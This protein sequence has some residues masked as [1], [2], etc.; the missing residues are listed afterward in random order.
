MPNYL[1]VF[2]NGGISEIEKRYISKE[3]MLLND[4]TAE[5]GI[6]LSEKDCADIAECRYESLKENERI[7]VGLGAVQKIIESFCDSGYVSQNNFTEIVEGLLECFYMIKSE[8]FDKVSDEEVLDFLKY[9]FE[10]ECGGEVSKIYD[11]ALLENFIREKNSY[12]QQ[13]KTGYYD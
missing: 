8:T 12:P 4:K 7:E 6:T 2:Q 1:A 10:N 5:Y 9:L 13:K 11:S 3:M